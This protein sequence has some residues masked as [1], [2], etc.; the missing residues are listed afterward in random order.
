MI[1]TYTRF[2]REDNIAQFSRDFAPAIA[3][4]MGGLLLVAQVGCSSGQE[5]WSMAASLEVANVPFR[6]E[7]FDYNRTAV[8]KAAEPYPVSGLDS[9]ARMQKE[10]AYPEACLGF[11]TVRAALSTDEWS[12]ATVTPTDSLRQ[13]ATLKNRDVIHK[14]LTAERYGAVVVNNVLYHLPRPDRDAMMWSLVASVRPGG[15]ILMEDY[16]H[17]GT[18][19]YPSWRVGIDKQFGLRPLN[20]RTSALPTIFRKPK[21]GK[22]ASA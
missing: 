13:K 5:T 14:P 17:A 7:G 9:L 8:R 21:V 19:D 15:A 22:A 18:Q 4:Q 12:G 10:S 6:I 3:Q 11:F 2:F 1:S 20:G 16:K